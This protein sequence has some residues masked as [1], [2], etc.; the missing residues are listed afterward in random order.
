MLEER[1]K[2]L[3][4]EIVNYAS[5]VELMIEKSIDGLSKRQKDL[6]ESVIEEHEIK[7]NEMEVQI[8]EHCVGTIAQFEP[9]ARDLRLILMILKMNNDLER[10]GD[11]AV[12]IADSASFLIELPVEES[13]EEIL[14]LADETKS[15]LKDSVDSFI[16]SDTEKAESVCERDDIADDLRDRIIRTSIKNMCAEPDTLDSIDQRMHII[17]IAKNLERMADLSTNICE[18]TIYTVKGKDI[19]HHREL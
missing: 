13:M 9:K 4:K 5:L 15:M 16:E 10:M 7:A 1:I 6:L 19:K 3:K 14:N 12:N 8:E 18:D 17:R 2:S 11:H